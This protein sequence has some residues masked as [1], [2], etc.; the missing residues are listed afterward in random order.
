MGEDLSVDKKNE[1]FNNFTYGI[2]DLWNPACMN[3]G[4]GIGGPLWG[5]SKVSDITGILC[6]HF[7]VGGVHSLSLVPSHA[8]TLLVDGGTYNGITING[9]GLYKALHIYVKGKMCQNAT[10]TFKHHHDCLV[11]ACAN[12]TA[13]PLND[14]DGNILVEVISAL[15]CLELDKAL[16]SV[17]ITNPVCQN[18]SFSVWVLGPISINNETGGTVQVIVSGLYED[19]AY[20][21]FGT[22]NENY[23]AVVVKD[24]N[25]YAPFG[26]Q[27]TI[28]NKVI[29]CAIPAG[30]NLQNI[31]L[32]IGNSNKTFRR[33]S[34]LNGNSNNI[35]IFAP[36]VINKTS[37]SGTAGSDLVITGTGFQR[38]LGCG[39]TLFLY[40]TPSDDCFYCLF[41]SDLVFASVSNDTS[42]TCTIPQQGTDSTVLVQI[43]LDGG[44]TFFSA[45]NFTYSQ[46]TTG[47]GTTAASTTA[48]S[49]V[50]STSSTTTTTTSESSTSSSDTTPVTTEP[51][52]TEKN[53]PSN[54]FVLVVS[55]IMLLILTL[56]Q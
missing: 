39:K 3:N 30:I 1:N 52:T 6:S 27:T 38:L 53:E 55:S 19:V 50:S 51:V 23:S 29:V 36:P 15:D 14:E 32:G 7:D 26:P 18:E 11:A 56:T 45:F 25:G 28:F 34:A 46:P 24:F 4:G 22:D 37:K 49:V 12:L 16:Q 21:T 47:G 20:C 10:S 5:P 44:L 54:S 41:G 48:P 2:T 31:V 13:A 43:T 40:A 8:Y 35:T 33:S 9:I 17:E 42:V